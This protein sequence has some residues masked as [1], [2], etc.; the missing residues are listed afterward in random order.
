MIGG[1]RF[2]A[3][4]ARWFDVNI[5]FDQEFTTGFS[6]MVICTFLASGPQ[7]H[8][9]G[10]FVALGSTTPFGVLLSPHLNVVEFFDGLYGI[11][12]GI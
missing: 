8:L 6:E 4:C 11:Y 9:C 7:C 5:V 10:T 1:V 2:S 12:V 3:V